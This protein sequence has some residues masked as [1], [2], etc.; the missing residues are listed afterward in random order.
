[1]RIISGNSKGKKILEPKDLS[2]RPLKDLT[3]ESIFNIIT[4]SNKF[5]VE[6]IDS[7]I[8]DLFSGVGSFGL[9]CLSRG[10]SNI[11]F[12]E[13]YINVLPILKKNILNLKYQDNSLIVEKNII[14][15]L[16][17]KIFKKQFDIIFLDPPYKEKN[18]SSVLN[19]IS[20]SK[21]LTPN[22][23]I[24]IHRH[25]KEEDKFPEKFNIIEKKIYGI[26]KVIFG[27]YF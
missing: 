17:F 15:S 27:N 10:S 24:I 14:S 12:V 6:L 26:S 11:T 13:N 7:N 3:K 18:L 21:I 1:M 2:T 25:K 19:K 20:E 23:I 22:G 5:T 8:L 4:H 9:E 16:N